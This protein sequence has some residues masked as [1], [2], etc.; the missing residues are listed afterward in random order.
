[1]RKKIRVRDPKDVVLRVRVSSRTREALGK[2]ARKRT[3]GKISALARHYILEG[4]KR[5]RRNV[6][7]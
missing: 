6:L 7:Q 3:K 5:E 1:M 2:L 4:L